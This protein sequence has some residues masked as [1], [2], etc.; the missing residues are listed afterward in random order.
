MF[1][2][3]NPTSIYSVL[4]RIQECY[5]I[6]V[7][8]NDGNREAVTQFEIS[9]AR[10]HYLA[11]FYH[12]SDAYPICSVLRYTPYTDRPGKF[13]LQPVAIFQIGP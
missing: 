13:Y 12:N 7:E 6:Y 8:R 9:T 10:R 2:Y 1:V 11:R 5:F 3:W 4:R